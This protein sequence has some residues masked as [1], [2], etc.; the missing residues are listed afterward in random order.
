MRILLNSGAKFCPFSPNFTDRVKF[1]AKR[2]QNLNKLI[3]S[4]FAAWLILPFTNDYRVFLPKFYCKFAKFVLEF[5]Q[6]RQFL[7]NYLKWAQNL[8]Y[9]VNLNTQ[10]LKTI[11]IRRESSSGGTKLHAQKSKFSDIKFTEQ[12]SAAKFSFKFK[13][14]A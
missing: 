13:D 9:A 12:S 4:A 3:F 14:I 11:K 5:P 10:I 1:N 8:P 2:R 6:T 7:K